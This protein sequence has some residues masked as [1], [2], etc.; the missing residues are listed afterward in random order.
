MMHLEKTW[1]SA[2]LSGL[3]SGTVA[4]VVS[5]VAL[6]ILGKAELGKF[7]APVNGPSQWI[8][9]RHAPYQDHFSLR[10]TLIGYAIHHAASIFWAIWYEKLRQQLP[11]AE[12]AA[13]ILAPAVATTAAAYAVDFHFTPKRLTPGFEH[14]LSQPS[15]LIV[16][17]TFALGL[18]M[19]VLL[20]RKP[21]RRR[22][23]ASRFA[24]PINVARGK[25]GVTAFRKH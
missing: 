13:T 15:L 20:Y 18:A 22:C 17:G 25:S 10:Y 11:P 23:T 16:Y 24:S 12:S 19:T 9:G 5:T 21:P 14:R 3:V 2:I 1:S 8:W 7:A 4:S 6:S